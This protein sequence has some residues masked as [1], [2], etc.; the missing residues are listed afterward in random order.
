MSMR[1]DQACRVS[2]WCL[3]LSLFIVLKLFQAAEPARCNLLGGF[4][5]NSTVKWKKI[6]EKMYVSIIGLKM[7]SKFWYR[8]STVTEQSSVSQSTQPWHSERKLYLPFAYS[9][10]GSLSFFVSANWNWKTYLKKVG[11]CDYQEEEGVLWK[12][13]LFQAQAQDTNQEC[14]Q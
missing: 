13:Q 2:W 8:A 3:P 10:I 11:Q 9:V 7:L 1:A 6:Q 5:A 4:T 12:V 14:F